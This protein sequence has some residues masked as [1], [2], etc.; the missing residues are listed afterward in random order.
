MEKTV[1]ASL[2][3]LSQLD[4]N[5]EL[6]AL[7]ILK[8]SLDVAELALVTM[9]PDMGEPADGEDGLSEEEAFA[10]AIRYQ[11]AALGG[12]LNHYVESVRRLQEWRSREPPEEADPF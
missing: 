10:T 8:T 11:I 4:E 9:Y 2:P 7:R 1:D 3:T 6:A 5:P 12:V